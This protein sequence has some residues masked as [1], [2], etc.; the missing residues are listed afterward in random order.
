MVSRAVAY[1]NVM[2]NWANLSRITFRKQVNYARTGLAILTYHREGSG[3]YN[4]KN[5]ILPQVAKPS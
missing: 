3:I 4:R 1:F 5:C 2:F